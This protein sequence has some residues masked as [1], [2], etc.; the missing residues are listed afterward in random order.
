M[1]LEGSIATQRAAFVWTRW[2]KV[3]AIRTSLTVVVVPIVMLVASV[4]RD[5]LLGRCAIFVFCFVGVFWRTSLS[6]SLLIFGGTN[7]IFLECG[8]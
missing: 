5:V 3:A 8:I 1:R 4:R 2:R 7:V 6:K